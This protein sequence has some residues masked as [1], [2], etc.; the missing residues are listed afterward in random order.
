MPTRGWILCETLFWVILAWFNDA[1][2]WAYT[3]IIM[4]SF[5]VGAITINQQTLLTQIQGLL[6]NPGSS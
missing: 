3:I 1:P 6:G 5:H 4:I 2:L